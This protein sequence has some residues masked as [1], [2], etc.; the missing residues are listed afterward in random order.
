MK[1]FCSIRLFTGCEVREEV[2]QTQIRLS[3]RRRGLTRRRVKLNWL[4]FIARPVRGKW[5]SE[6]CICNRYRALGRAA[7][8]HNDLRSWAG[9]KLCCDERSAKSCLK[10]FMVKL[11]GGLEGFLAWCV[12]LTAVS[13]S[14]PLLACLS[15]GRKEKQDCHML[16]LYRA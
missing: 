12:Q 5:R 6:E 9:A 13:V 15:S 2:I 16:R 3:S 11:T 8:F 7:L 4:Y 10:S 1:R 14:S